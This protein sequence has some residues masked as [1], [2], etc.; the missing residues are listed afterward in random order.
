M[1]RYKPYP[2]YKDSGVEWIGKVPVEWQVKR[3]RHIAIFNNSNVDKKS[4]EGQQPIK[5]CNYTDV[6]YNEFITSD[7]NFMEATGSDIEIERFRLFK[8]DVIITKDSEAP[9]DIGIPAMVKE[10]LENVICG[11]HLTLIRTSEKELSKFI[12]RS[13]QAISTKTY[14]LVNS[15]GVTRYGLNQDVIGNILICVP[16]IQEWKLLVKKINQ[17]TTHIDALIQKKTRF[18]ELLKEKRQALIT[19]A[20]TKG[21]DPDVPMKDS[22]VEWIGMVPEGW[23]VGQFKRLVSIQNGTDHKMVESDKGFPVYGSGGLFAYASSYLY[24]QESVLL[25]RKGTLDRPLYVNEKFWTV[26]TM[27]WTKILPN[28]HG[29]FC[30]YTATTIPF[31]YYSTN[32]ALPSM[33][34]SALGGHLITIPKKEEQ[35]RI[36]KFI[37]QET[38]RIDTLITKTEQS[39]ALLKERRT[40]FITAAVTGKIDLRGESI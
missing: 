2:A 1:S 15:L 3:L 40:A 11:Y 26:D 7:L 13:I 4:Y 24:D 36:A 10:D 28:A 30:Y 6:Y 34:K 22:G 9:S 12:H 17:E 38:T 8:W 35:I 23:K 37:D 32:T 21:L 25:G 19:H 16:P 18:I 14:F 29:K 27:Y 20:V 31:P 39:I 5:L 33:T